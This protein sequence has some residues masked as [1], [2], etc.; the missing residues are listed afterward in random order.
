MTRSHAT[1]FSARPRPIGY[2][3]WHDLLFLHWP[4]PPQRLANLLPPDVTVDTWQGQ[5]WIGLV[6]FHMSGIRPWWSPPIWRLSAFPEINVRTYVRRAGDDEPAVWF[7]SLDAARLAAVLVARLR[8][9]LPYYWARARVERSPGRVVYA[10]RRLDQS[11]AHS[12]IDAQLDPQAQATGAASG[13]FEHFLVERYVFYNRT[14]DGRLQRGRVRHD[15]Y[16]LWPARLRS[17]DES[18]TAPLGLAVDGPPKHVIFS[19]GVA[20][21]IEPVRIVQTVRTTRGERLQAV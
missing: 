7:L 2:H 14:R 10:S 12:S 17:F 15:P 5:A 16:P 13:S 8:W 1:D 18:L 21:A 6:A 9:H 3:R 4:V 20:V 19:P 11:G